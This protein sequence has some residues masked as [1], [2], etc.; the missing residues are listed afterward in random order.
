[1]DTSFEEV[2]GGPIGLAALGL[3]AVPPVRRRVIAVARAVGRG[4]LIIL[5]GVAI[6]VIDVVSAAVRG[7]LVAAQGE[8]DQARQQTA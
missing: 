7:E 5:G 2:P 1:M 4:S 6:T 3:V 8:G